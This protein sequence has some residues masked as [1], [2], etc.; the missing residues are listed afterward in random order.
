MLF[1]IGAS[2]EGDKV[3]IDPKWVKVVG[4]A[5]GYPSTILACALLFMNLIEQGVL[6]KGLGWSLFLLIVLQS[7]FLI[8]W[9][10]FRAKKEE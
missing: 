3:K 10:A 9:Y 7:L 6:S 2:P 5:L 1:T 4:L 8:V